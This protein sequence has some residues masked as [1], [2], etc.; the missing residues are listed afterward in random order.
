MK[1]RIKYYRGG[2]PYLTDKTFPTIE[3]ATAHASLLLTLFPNITYIVP[4][5]E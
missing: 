2:I 1:I 4:V 5:I 3:S